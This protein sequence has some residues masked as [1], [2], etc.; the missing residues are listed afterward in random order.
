MASKGKKS[1]DSVI[2]KKLKEPEDIKEEDAKEAIKGLRLMMSNGENPEYVMEKAL[3]YRDRTKHALVRAPRTEATKLKRFF[4]EFHD[5]GVYCAKQSARIR[6]EGLRRKANTT[7]EL[8]NLKENV[9]GLREDLKESMHRLGGDGVVL[10]EYLE[11][12]N[13]AVALPVQ[14]NCDQLL[15]Y[16][17]NCA[18][19]LSP[20]N[21]ISESQQIQRAIEKMM[22]I[23]GEEGKPLKQ[24]ITRVRKLRESIATNWAKNAIKGVVE[25]ERSAEKKPRKK[26]AAVKKAKKEAKAELDKIKKLLGKESHILDKYYERLRSIS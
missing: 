19:V 12:L 21:C 4:K 1:G 26:A 3:A 6:V 10:K 2:V 8:R 15:G 20:E 13:R 24:Y 5:I 25:A 17:N 7:D 23:L 18:G 11:V 16:L 14:D 22:E 9:D